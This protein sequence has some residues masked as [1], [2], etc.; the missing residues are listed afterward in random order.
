LVRA[1]VGEQIAA[2]APWLARANCVEATF[3]GEPSAPAVSFAV[4]YETRYY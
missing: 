4:G 1:G 2:L 3:S